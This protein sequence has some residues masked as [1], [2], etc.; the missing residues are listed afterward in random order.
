MACVGGLSRSQPVPAGRSR[1]QPGGRQTKWRRCLPQ[2]STAGGSA[3]QLGETRF[4]TGQE[5]SGQGTCEVMPEERRRQE[6]R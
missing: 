3:R 1:F 6:G 5:V 2:A 4:E